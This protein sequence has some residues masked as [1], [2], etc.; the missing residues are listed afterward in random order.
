MKLE[1]AEFNSVEIMRMASEPS[2]R[3]PGVRYVTVLPGHNISRKAGLYS[4]PR[5][6]R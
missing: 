5:T 2:K 3:F 4:G 1:S 6:F